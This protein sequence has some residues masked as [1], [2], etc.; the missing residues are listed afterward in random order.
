MSITLSNVQP[1]VNPVDFESGRIEDCK[2][3]CL[4]SCSCTGYA[5][6]DSRCSIW[7]GDLM[8]L[9]QLADYNQS[10]RD[11]YVKVAA[12]VLNPKS[13]RILSLQ[14]SLRLYDLVSI[15]FYFN[16]S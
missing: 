14:Q 9:R 16:L 13:E 5:F 12:S 6:Y 1:P 11:I 15:L 10:A 7:N 2:S 8:N 4:N 3:A